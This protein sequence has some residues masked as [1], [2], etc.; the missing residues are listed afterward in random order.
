VGADLSPGTAD[1]RHDL[2]AASEAEALGSAGMGGTIVGDVL[3]A[4][5]DAHVVV[6]ADLRQDWDATAQGRGRIDQGRR[7]LESLRRD[8]VHPDGGLVGLAS[9]KQAQG[10]WLLRG[11]LGSGRR[12]GRPLGLRGLLLLEGLFPWIPGTQFWSR[13]RA[14]AAHGHGDFRG[15]PEE[16]PQPV[17]PE[18]AAAFFVTSLRE[19]GELLGRFRPRVKGNGAGILA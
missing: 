9:L 13:L 18:R 3:V 1:H 6:A 14:N 12:C 5:P 2:L 15:H 10:T 16:K 11:I 19:M 4:F 8:A 17:A 7:T